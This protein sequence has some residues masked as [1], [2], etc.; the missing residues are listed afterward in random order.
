MSLGGGR[1]PGLLLVVL[2]LV[3]VLVLAP[4]AGRRRGK[5][6]PAPCAAVPQ[7][8]PSGGARR[9]REGRVWGPAVVSPG[10]WHPPRGRGVEQV[11]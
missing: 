7:P 9:G 4:C 3:L 10:W 1:A 6:G 5:C 8:K 2:A 11:P